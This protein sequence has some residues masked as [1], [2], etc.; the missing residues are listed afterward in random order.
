MAFFNS[1]AGVTQTAH[2]WPTPVGLAGG[3]GR[4]FWPTLVGEIGRWC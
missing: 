1:A 3:A 4:A 2:S